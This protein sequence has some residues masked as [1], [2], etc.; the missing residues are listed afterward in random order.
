MAAGVIDAIANYRG[1]SVMIGIAQT[2][3]SMTSIFM[4]TNT[5]VLDGIKRNPVTSGY[6]QDPTAISQVKFDHLPAAANIPRG[7]LVV[8]GS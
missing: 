2:S 5:I 6:T 1:R 7:A 4:L 8:V 3:T